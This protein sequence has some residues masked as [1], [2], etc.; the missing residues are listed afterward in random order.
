MEAA[1]PALRVGRGPQ[2]S[3]T[4]CDH[5][6]STEGTL[7]MKKKHVIAGTLVILVATCLGTV[8]VG[9]TPTIVK[10]GAKAVAQGYVHIDPSDPGVAWV[11][12]RYSCPAGEA[13][14]WVSVKQV[15]DGRPDG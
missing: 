9:A 3:A 13:N 12:G 2:Y 4:D 11:T 5:F 8:S 7:R 1:R 6:S 15:A 14:L 10:S